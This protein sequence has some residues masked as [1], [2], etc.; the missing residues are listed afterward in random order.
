[1]QIQLLAEGVASERRM[2]RAENLAEAM[3]LV[4]GMPRDKNGRTVY[5]REII[6]QTL[7]GKI[8][9]PVFRLFAQKANVWREIEMVGPRAKLMFKA[10]RN[11]RRL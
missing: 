11:P 10:G 7:K 1:M 6:L 9:I 8:P 4:K 2:E 3:I 5:V